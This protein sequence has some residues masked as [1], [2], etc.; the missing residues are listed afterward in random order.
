M[1]VCGEPIGYRRS[2]V[3]QPLRCSLLEQILKRRP[4]IVGPGAGRGPSLFLA[5]HP[6]LEQFAVI[7][8]IF[9]RDALLYRLHALEPAPRI[10]IGALL[11]GMQLESA[12]R[13][14]A[15]SRRSL[16]DVAALCAT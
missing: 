13:T 6:N 8:R 14:L 7:A 4:R 15:T 3:P 1:N 5:R 12:L 9:L 16:Q 11:A 2:E 10:E